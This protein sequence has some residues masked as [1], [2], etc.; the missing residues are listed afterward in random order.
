M[1]GVCIVSLS[2]YSMV[3]VE[4]ACRGLCGL[5]SIC[6]GSLM[7]FNRSIFML[8]PRVTQNSSKHR[9]ARICLLSLNDRFRLAPDPGGEDVSTRNLVCRS[10]LTV[11]MAKPACS[12]HRSERS[13]DSRGVFPNLR[14]TRRNYR[15]STQQGN[16]FASCYLAKKRRH[17]G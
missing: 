14:A 4:Y 12:S 2:Q 3:L 10:G 16:A 5:W 17:P 13:S 11:L 15:A 8:S 7:E 6:P 1:A 9:Q